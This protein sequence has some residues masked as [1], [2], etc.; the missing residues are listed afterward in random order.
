MQPCQT[1]YG[2][3]PVMASAFAFKKVYE[4][5]LAKIREESS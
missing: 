1:P 2:S 3:V 5:D 4:A